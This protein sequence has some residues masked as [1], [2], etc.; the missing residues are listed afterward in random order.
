[1]PKRTVE[2]KIL[3][4][5]ERI[6]DSMGFFEMPE[7]YAANTE[8]NKYNRFTGYIKEA[9][10]RLIKGSSDIKNF[11]N[12]D[13]DRGAF[14][15]DW[16]SVAKRVADGKRV[17]TPIPQIRN[18]TE[19]DKQ[20]VLTSLLPAYRVLKENFDN[21]RWYEWIFNHNQYTAERDNI[22]ALS[23]LI[24]SLTGMTK[25]DLD[26]AVEAHRKKVGTS[27]IS[28]EKRRE[29][30]DGIKEERIYD[31]KL[32][33][34]KKWDAEYKE[35]YGSPD[36][37]ESEDEVEV[38]SQILDE[39]LGIPRYD[40]IFTQ[41]V[42]DYIAAEQKYTDSFFDEKLENIDN[43]DSE[44]NPDKEQVVFENNE[45]SGLDDG[46][47][48]QKPVD[49]KNDLFIDNEKDAPFIDD[50]NDVPVIDNK[51]QLGF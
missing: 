44:I 18:V 33:I 37:S 11:E 12:L 7:D 13:I 8:L 50:E 19:N 22:K 5:W 26:D 30:L 25:D 27:G 42:N 46:F 24:T 43:F 41:K 17:D 31:I 51:S 47:E 15:D 4:A 48:I 2:Q 36:N 32:A 29:K 49:E 40:R 21:R 20:I 14:P 3:Y 35:K 23:G 38:E 45:F 39:L 10:T 6:V 16:W 9:V 34:A 28:A 1:M